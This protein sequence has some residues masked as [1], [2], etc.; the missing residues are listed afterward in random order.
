MNQENSWS[1]KMKQLK[2]SSELKLGKYGGQLEKVQTVLCSL[3]YKQ[4]LSPERKA[5]ALEVFNTFHLI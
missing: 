5:E 2:V 1:G 3:I 4:C